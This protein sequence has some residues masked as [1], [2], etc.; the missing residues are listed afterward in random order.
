[1]YRSLGRLRF[2]FLVLSVLWFLG[3]G[4]KDLGI[5]EHGIKESACNL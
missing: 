3:G 4:E 5:I 1:M 2:P